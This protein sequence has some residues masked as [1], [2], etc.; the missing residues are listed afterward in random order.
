MKGYKPVVVFGCLHLGH[1]NADLDM[2]KRYVE[3]VKKND[4]AA[5]LLSDNFENVIPKKG[6]MMFDQVMI[7]Q[8]QLDYGQ[9]LFYPIRKNVIGIVQGNHSGRTRHEAGLD[10]DYELAK[11]LGKKNVYFPNQGYVTVKAGKQSYAIAFKHGTGFGANTFG[12]CVTLMRHFPSVDIVAC[13]HTHE[14]ASTSKGFWDM[15]DGKRVRHDVTL[16]NTGSLL[17]YPSYADEA[18]Y[19]PQRKGFA[20]L[21][22]NEKTKEV[23]VDISGRI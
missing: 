23:V 19:A 15:K 5:L 22:L 9:E 10:M 6:H 21:W 7:P 2:A 11:Y 14:L 13:S 16:V 17:D 12:N 20:I 18:Y 8:E 3:F 4:A 1:R